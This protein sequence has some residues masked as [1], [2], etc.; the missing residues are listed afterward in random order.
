M[1]WEVILDDDFKLWLDQQQQGIRK[2]IYAQ[3]VLLSERG[4]VLSR[5]QVDTLKSS[6]IP[7]LKELR[8]QYQGEPWR[9][10]FAFD[11]TRKAILLVGGCKQGKN[12]WYD[13]MIPIAEKR[14]DRHL[15]KLKKEEDNGNKT[16]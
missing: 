7:H 13:K 12:R 8:I 4:P 16:I 5:P 9:V 10:L 2:A 15:K 3:A 6:K 11:P 1:E 14:Y